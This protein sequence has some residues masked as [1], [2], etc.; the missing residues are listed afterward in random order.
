MSVHTI[1]EF[2]QQNSNNTDGIS[3]EASQVNA[4]L[5]IIETLQAQSEGL[6]VE[7]QKTIEELKGRVKELTERQSFLE[8]ELLAEKKKSEEIK[9]QHEAQEK[10]RI[11]Q[12]RA[13][14]EAARR[15]NEEKRRQLEAEKAK[16]R[17]QIKTEIWKATSNIGRI[18]FFLNNF[19]GSVS[20]E[21]EPEQYPWQSQF[22]YEGQFHN[23][24]LMNLGDAHTRNVLSHER[25]KWRSLIDS[26]NTQLRAIT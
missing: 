25:D 5:H 3:G 13:C 2:S 6:S 19:Q 12:E 9:K 11:Q 10:A 8:S 24:I 4:L 21:R 14:L 20:C 15:A 7:Q 1:H 16:K 18:E 22:P 23:R 17:D 26:L